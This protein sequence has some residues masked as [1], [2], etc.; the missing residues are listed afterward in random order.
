MQSLLIEHHS[1]LRY[2][3]FRDF[4]QH[5][6]VVFLRRFGTTYWSCLQGSSSSRRM[7][8]TLTFRYAI[9]YNCIPKCSHHSSW[10]VW[11]LKMGPIGCPETSVTK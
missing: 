1:Y 8:G 9:V 7:P 5:R 4:V 6:L 11:P 2:V 10:T 3:L